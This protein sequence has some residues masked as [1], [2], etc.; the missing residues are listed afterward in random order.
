[1]IPTYSDYI[2]RFVRPSDLCGRPTPGEHHFVSA[3][4]VPKLFSLN[5]VVPDYINPDGTKGILGDVVYYHNHKHH[6]GIE[7]KLGVVRLTKREFNEWIVNDDSSH[8]PNLFIGVGH[9]G[10]ALSTWGRFREAYV[11]SVRSKN[12]DWLAVE[13]ADGYGP[14]KNVDQLIPFF[15]GST[16]FPWQQDVKASNFYEQAFLESLHRHLAANHPLISDPINLG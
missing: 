3:Y 16:W 4:L 6:F 7:A 12:A 5:G 11:A 1:M 10:I 13:L 9:A 14:M 15:D 2:S 8:W